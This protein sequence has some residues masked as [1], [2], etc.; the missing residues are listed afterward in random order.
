MHVSFR[1]GRKVVSV[2][3]PDDAIVYESRFPA[4][5]PAAQLVAA[6]LDKPV[7][8]LPLKE[9]LGARADGDVVIV[10]SDVTR[11]IPYAEFLPQMMAAVESAGVPRE[12]ILILIATGMHRPSTEEER[13]EMFGPDI[14]ERYRIVDHAADDPGDLV[15]LS[16][17]SWSGSAVRLNRRYVEAGFRIVTGLVEPHFMA[18]FS[19]GR[20]AIFPGLTA[21]DSICKFHSYEFLADSRARN[22]ILDGNPC[23]LES[24]SAARLAGVDFSLNIVLNN[25]RETVAA[26]AG[27]LEGAH[28]EAC[29]FVR[30]CA[31][32]PVEQSA[33]IVL[34]SC[35]GYPLDTTFYQ[36]V[37]GM[38][39]CL[40]ALRDG[41]TVVAF[42]GCS[43]GVG[44]PE[45]TE[46]LTKY[47][48]RWREFLTDIQ[49]P[50]PFI[51]DQWQFQMQCLA[52]EKA[53]EGNLIFVTDGLDQG[54][55]DTLSV[56]GQTAGQGEVGQ[57]LS[58]IMHRQ[59]YQG[60][61]VA[62]FPEG[63]YCAPVPR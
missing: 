38:V 29:A 36:C 32:R 14:V 39:S 18:G 28:R 27:E 35:G 40:P 56:N 52:L 30:D 51:K 4:P 26:F 46:T 47:S 49:R 22:G 19:G 60:K 41:G 33:D 54:Q 57:V 5:T 12:E 50:G 8:S 15:A 48:G 3:V 42:G 24:L 23:H 63:P 20:K 31:I 62:V 45:Y 59:S 1:C 58:E 2:D 7:D 55:L 17:K 43:E 9:A 61:Q 10:V 11:P 21:L 25:D 44:S 53:G 6:A 13:V 34:T 37:K 16:G